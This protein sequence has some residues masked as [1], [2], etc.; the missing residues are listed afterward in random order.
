MGGCEGMLHYGIIPLEGQIQILPVSKGLQSYFIHIHTPKA[1]DIVLDFSLNN[2]K[3]FRF[4]MNLMANLNQST[5]LYF[6]IKRATIVHVKGMG[7]NFIGL[8][9]VYA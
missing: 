6:K 3:P 5:K 1:Y 2:R 4:G 8:F 7:A 9:V